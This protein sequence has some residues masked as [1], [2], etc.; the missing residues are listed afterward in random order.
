MSNRQPPLYLITG[1]IIGVLVGLFFS[2]VVLPLHYMDTE[3]YSLSNSQKAI[4]RNQV[5]RAYLYEADSGRAFSRL[6]LLQ[7][8]DTGSEL[9]AQ[10]QQL[11][12]VDGDPIA[13]RGL[14]LLVSAITQPGFQITPLVVA[15]PTLKLVIQITPTIL[16]TRTP[17]QATT[18]P[19]ATFTPRPTAT[20]KPTQSSPYKKISQNEVCG[21]PA[22]TNLLMVYIFNPD[23]DGVIGI[24]VEISLPDGGS[25]YFYTGF[26]P[27]IN[28]GY[29]DYEMLPDEEYQI[30]V[31]EAG[32]VIKGL[33]APQCT[34][35]KGKSF[36]GGLEIKFKQQ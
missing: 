25:S 34:D 1:I 21:N 29:A 22:Q 31:G 24:R 6:N 19:F 33:K 15:T 4:Y 35:S 23:G 16:A 26:Y 18:T 8:V 12:A 28:P 9:V 14:A 10:A 11:L 13:A 36:T 3:P 30:R 17:I 5:A 27:E 7:D 20:A 32:E 2:Y